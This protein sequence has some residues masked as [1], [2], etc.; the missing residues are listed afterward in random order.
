M[1]LHSQNFYHKLTPYMFLLL[2][3]ICFKI[4]QKLHIIAKNKALRQKSVL[5]DKSPR[6][7]ASF[8]RMLSLR[9]IRKEIRKSENKIIVFFKPKKHTPLRASVPEEW[10]GFLKPSCFRW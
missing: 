2:Y 10:L 1:K 6:E 9:R 7:Y 5:M 8:L 4:K 3:S